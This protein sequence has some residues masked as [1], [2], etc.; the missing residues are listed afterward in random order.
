M[1]DND[2]DTNGTN[3]DIEVAPDWREK[4]KTQKSFLAA[5]LLGARL[6]VLLAGLLLLAVATMRT[7][8]GVCVWHVD[9]EASDYEGTER[10]GDCDRCGGLPCELT[11]DPASGVDDDGWIFVLSGCW[12]STSG[13]ALFLEEQ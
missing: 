13:L 8:S 1:A 3:A 12:D 9:L 7:A 11:A 10:V 5:V 2:A 6:S 4:M